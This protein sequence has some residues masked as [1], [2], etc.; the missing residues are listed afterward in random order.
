MLEELYLIKFMIFNSKCLQMTDIVLPG[1]FVLCPED[2]DYGHRTEDG[3][4]AGD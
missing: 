4:D 2:R 3:G 1:R